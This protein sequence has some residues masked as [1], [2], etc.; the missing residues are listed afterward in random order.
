MIAYTLYLVLAVAVMFGYGDMSGDNGIRCA[1]VLLL[2][3][4]ARNT[5]FGR[6]DHNA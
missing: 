2:I 1:V 4:L 6:K 3:L 5:T